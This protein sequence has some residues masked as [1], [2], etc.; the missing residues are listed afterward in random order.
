MEPVGSPETDLQQF[1]RY[2]VQKESAKTAIDL[3]QQVKDQLGSSANSNTRVVSKDSTIDRDL[4]LCLEPTDQ[5]NQNSEI[6][7][8]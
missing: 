2:T 8:N 5:L 1:S 4:V 3:H 7:K 6:L